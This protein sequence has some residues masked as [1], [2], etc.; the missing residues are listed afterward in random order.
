[1]IEQFKYINHEN[2]VISFGEDG[3]YVNEN[4]LRD[5][6]WELSS[7]NNRIVGFSRTS[8]N[9][10]LPVQ[11][12]LEDADAANQLKDYIY[13]TCEKDVLAM[14][15]GRIVLGDYYMKGYMTASAKTEY[16]NRKAALITMTFDTDRPFWIR[17]TEHVF[18]YGGTEGSNL[19]F[20]ND[21]S[22]DYTSNILGT[23]L[24]NPNFIE[25][26]F[27]MTIFGPAENPAV[28]I[29]GHVY[30]VSASVAA[31]EFL[32]IDSIEKTVMLTKQTAEVV[33]CFN[34]RNRESYVFEK[35]PAGVSNV[36]LSSDF[37]LKI[38]LL[39]ERSEPRWT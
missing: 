10:K 8:A 16:S 33:N 38:T 1:M 28:V 26:N 20:N 12:A 5:F 32:T 21:F 2:E 24:I 9:K 22:Y 29:G 17:E 6:V 15:Y 27:R 34:L 7:K 30:S 3:A 36:S 11:I 19:D 4:D 35:I 13:E 31:N 23:Q 37:K 25:S 14:Q 18:G 39:E